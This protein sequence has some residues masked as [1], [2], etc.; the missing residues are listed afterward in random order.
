MKLKVDKKKNKNI[1]YRCG[2]HKSFINKEKIECSVWGKSYKK[3][4]YK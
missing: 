2:I 4:I 1:C 3:H